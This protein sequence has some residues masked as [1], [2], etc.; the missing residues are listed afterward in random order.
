[1]L[2]LNVHSNLKEVEKKLSA[3]ALRQVPFA[4]SQALTALANRIVPAEQAN[5]QR[6]LDRPKPF[7]QN[8]IGVVRANTKRM[9]ATVF[10]K[11]ITA[12][13]L[14]PYEF[15]GRNRLNSRALLKPID[16]V[17]DLDQY[18]NL[19]RNW[20]AKMRG[21]AD[22]F[23]GTVKTKTGE[24]NGVWQ[25]T[26]A[27]GDAVKVRREKNGRTRKNLNTSGSLKLLVRFT[28]AHDV[29]QHLDWFGVA[30]RIVDKDFSREFGRALAKAMA[31]AR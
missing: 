1:M 20:L 19:P 21:R 12:R 9:T 5:E 24:I 28:E 13:Y 3:F 27:P 14:E 7:T 11:D 22:I 16:A 23:I 29:K 10:M 15:G 2:L 30:R 25:R 26:V 6:V 17:K 4:T 31:T 18:G 8:A